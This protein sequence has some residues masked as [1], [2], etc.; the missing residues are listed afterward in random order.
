MT[1]NLERTSPGASGLPSLRYRGR[2]GLS[3]IGDVVD[4]IRYWRECIDASQFKPFSRFRHHWTHGPYFAQAA[5][6]Q[7]AR[8][9]AVESDLEEGIL[10]MLEVDNR[11]ILLELTYVRFIITTSDIIYS[12]TYPS[13]SI[14]AN[15]YLG[16]LN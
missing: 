5:R 16:R 13:L 7:A 10:R 11:V 12:F 9:Q 1:A 2:A 14:K 4:V 8:S 15:V 6:F 3:G